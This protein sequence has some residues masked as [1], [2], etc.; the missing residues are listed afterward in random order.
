[1]PKVQ[2]NG[3]D[4]AGW[5][6][7]QHLADVSKLNLSA[8]IR[9][10]LYNVLVLGYT[11]EHTERRART[12]SRYRGRMARNKVVRVPLD[13]VKLIDI[14][15]KEDGVLHHSEGSRMQLVYSVAEMALMYG[16]HFAGS[17]LQFYHACGE[18]HE[19]Q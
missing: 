6:Q 9:T 14:R 16:L 18:C 7:L 4:N 19:F 11:V 10:M 5:Q 15:R 12:Q 17:T 1:M 8:Y 3:L 13:L 2:L